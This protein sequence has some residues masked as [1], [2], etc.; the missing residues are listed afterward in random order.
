MPLIILNWKCGENLDWMG[1]E[2]H[3]TNVIIFQFSTTLSCVKNQKRVR[4][5]ITI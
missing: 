5:N 3:L 1:K 4:Q 2:T